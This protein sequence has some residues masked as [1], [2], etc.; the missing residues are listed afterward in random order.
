M[1]TS[2]LIFFI[3]PLLIMFESASGQNASCHFDEERIRLSNEFP[4]LQRAW[5][6]SEYKAREEM[7][8]SVA[9]TTTVTIPV[10]VHVVYHTPSENISDQQIQSQIDVLNED[11]RM[12]NSDT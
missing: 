2:R 10:V 9:R 12:M 8:S 4:V 1:K 5:E 7:N 11:F 6:V 3:T